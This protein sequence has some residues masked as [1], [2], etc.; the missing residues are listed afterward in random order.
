MAVSTQYR[1]V[2]EHC[3][4]N[5]DSP[6]CPGRASTC[7]T[8]SFYTDQDALQQLWTTRVV[9]LNLLKLEK[10]YASFVA[11]QWYSL[12][13]ITWS[14]QGNWSMEHASRF[15]YRVLIYAHE[16]CA[17]KSC[18]QIRNFC[19]F[20]SVF[21]VHKDSLLPHTVWF[22]QEVSKRDSSVMISVGKSSF[23][24]IPRSRLQSSSSM[25]PNQ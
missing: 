22:I 8:I 18:V 23:K 13:P 19:W 5:F 9:W 4:W 24:I 17:N 25:N 16:T 12:K 15:R 7:I 20:T 6:S 10:Y 2:P 14:T 1:C 11:A 3:K 21:P